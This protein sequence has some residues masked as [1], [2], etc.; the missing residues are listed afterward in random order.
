MKIG[1]SKASKKEYRHEVP[2]QVIELLVSTLTEGSAA[3]RPVRIRDIQPLTDSEGRHVPYYQVYDSVAWLRSHGLLR[4]HGHRGYM[5]EDAKD[6]VEEVEARFR[7]LPDR[8]EARN[9]G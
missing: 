6:L 4:K 1:W 9:D 3:G 2:R 5:A 8:A 7:R